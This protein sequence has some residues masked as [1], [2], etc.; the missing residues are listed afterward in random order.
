MIRQGAWLAIAVIVA[1]AATAVAARSPPVAPAAAPSAWPPVTRRAEL[2][3]RLAAARLAHRPVMIDFYADWCAACRLLDRNTLADREV[4]VALGRFAVV[5][6][7]TSDDDG[8]R[9]GLAARF[10]VTKLPALVFVGADG[11]VS[12]TRVTGYV[13]ARE[14]LPVLRGVR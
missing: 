11:S 4:A 5:R 1:L 12:P 9:S 7:D 6:V 8:D 3:A 14:L 2:D 10:A 13:G